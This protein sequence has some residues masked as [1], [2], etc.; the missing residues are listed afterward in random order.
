MSI[1]PRQNVPF[2]G[3]PH[4]SP[5]PM[6][7]KFST[8]E[9]TFTELLHAKFHPQLVLHVASM[10]RKTS[11]SSLDKS[12]YDTLFCALCNAGGNQTYTP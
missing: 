8:E 11:I 1:A 5:V 10:G 9:W 6:E 7:V 12:K 2:F 3:A 4:P